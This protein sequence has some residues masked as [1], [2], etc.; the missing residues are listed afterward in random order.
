MKKIIAS[1]LLASLFGTTISM[2]TTE[3]CQKDTRQITPPETNQLIT[4]TVKA[5]SKRLSGKQI[6][7]QLI[8]QLEPAA[9]A[10]AHQHNQNLSEKK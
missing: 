6:P 8:S 4:N 7:Q 9:A 1:C 2:E 5:R 10:L 3:K